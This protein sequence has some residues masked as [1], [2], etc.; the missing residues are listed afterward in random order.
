MKP[1]P[2]SSTPSPAAR[3]KKP[4]RASAS[5]KAASPKSS[6]SSAPPAPSPTTSSPESTAASRTDLLTK[7]DIARRLG[8]SRNAVQ[9]HIERWGLKPVE[10]RL[11]SFA[12]YTSTTERSDTS[13]TIEQ[14]KRDDLLAATRLKE[15]RI[16]EAEGRLISRDLAIDLL[17]SLAQAYLS[18]IQNILENRDDCANAQAQLRAD[19]SAILKR[20]PRLIENAQ[21]KSETAP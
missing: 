2:S 16:A 19:Y 11:Y 21:A 6:P 8:I 4:P 14:A 5:P 3:A 1:A 18:S 10:G 9:H 13:K 15:L 17:S 20:L 12:Q 7:A